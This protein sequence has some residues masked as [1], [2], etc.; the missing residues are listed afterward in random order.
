MLRSNP[1]NRTPLLKQQPLA[2][3]TAQPVVRLLRCSSATP[4]QLQFLEWIPATGTA[5]EA[6][7]PLRVKQGAVHGLSAQ[8][9]RRPIAPPGGGCGRSA[10]ERTGAR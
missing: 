10:G 9:G 6:V 2:N 4:E 3:G 1:Q 7:D 8:A 5:I